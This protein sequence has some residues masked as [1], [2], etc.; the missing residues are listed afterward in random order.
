MLPSTRIVKIGA[1]ILSHFFPFGGA[2]FSAF[3]DGNSLQDD[4]TEANP[5]FGYISFS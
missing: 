5:V 2:K 4:G 1:L 3:W